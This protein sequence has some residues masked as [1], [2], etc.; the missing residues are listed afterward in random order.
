MPFLL[1]LLVNA[2]ALYAATRWVDGIRYAGEPLGLLAVALV[3]G[4]VN[5]FIAP[6]LKFFSLPLIFLTLGI[7]ALVINGLML[8]LTS[9]V[10]SSLGFA[11][12]VQDFG[13]AFWGALCISV[14]SVILGWLVGGETTKEK[15]R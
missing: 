4:V 14:V 8:M 3:F 10:A 13:S 2:V 6:V 15:E 9:R 11:F 7:F 12:T 1:R 5:S